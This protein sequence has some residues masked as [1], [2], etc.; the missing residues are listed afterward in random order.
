MEN[1]LKYPNLYEE[2]RK[3]P[4]GELS[5]KKK[6]PSLETIASLSAENGFIEKF[7]LNEQG[8]EKVKKLRLERNMEKKEDYQ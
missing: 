8:Q 3:Y 5:V 4:E 2:C 6:E 1:E 7:C